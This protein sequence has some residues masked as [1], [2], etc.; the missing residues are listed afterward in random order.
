M[1]CIDRNFRGLCIKMDTRRD[2]RFFPAHLEFAAVDERCRGRKCVQRCVRTEGS[3]RKSCFRVGRIVAPPQVAAIEADG[4][5]IGL[6]NQDAGHDPPWP[7]GEL[8]QIGVMPEAATAGPPYLLRVT[9]A[10]RQ[11]A[12]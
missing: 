2:P 7:H 5:R 11:L 10:R 3:S 12:L 6:C 9:A 1:C 8:R 4:S